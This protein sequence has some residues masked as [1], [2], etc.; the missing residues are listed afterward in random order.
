MPKTMANNK[1]ILCLLVVGHC[2]LVYYIHFS[3]KLNRENQSIIDILESH[4]MVPIASSLPT[5][6]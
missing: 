2:I 1:I 5:S 3:Q 6:K 4:C